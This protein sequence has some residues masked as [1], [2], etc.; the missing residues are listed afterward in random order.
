M[1]LVHTIQSI[2]FNSIIFPILLQL[3]SSP[4]VEHMEP[5]LFT[6]GLHFPITVNLK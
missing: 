4:T 6:A 5:K 3:Q 1:I 2:L